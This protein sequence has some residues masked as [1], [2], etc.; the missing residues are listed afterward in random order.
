M[1]VDRTFIKRWSVAYPANEDTELLTI[2]GPSVRARGAYDR[3]DLLAVGDWKS[4]RVR[5]RL[6]SNSDELIHDVTLTA[7]AAPETIKHSVLTLL[8]GVGIPM[9]SAMLTAWNPDEFTVLDVRALASLRATGELNSTGPPSYTSYLQL[10]RRIARRC[11]CD[12][13]TLDR[14]L[15]ASNGRL[16]S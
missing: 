9:A 3:T 6:D 1:T 4:P 2:V 14:A 8:S 12:L 5:G 13:R 15:W 10:C 11:K 16:T 7:L